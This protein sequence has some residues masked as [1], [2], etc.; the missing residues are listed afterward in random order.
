MGKYDY[1]IGKIYSGTYPEYKLNKILN[2][3]GKVS[4]ELDEFNEGVDVRIDMKKGEVDNLNNRINIIEIEVNGLV[5]QKL[6]AKRVMKNLS[7][8][9]E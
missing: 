8:L 4:K 5:K 6:R 9:V 2:M 3:F 7:K 1:L